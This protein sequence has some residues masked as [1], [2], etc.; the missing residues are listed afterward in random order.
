[1]T[2]AVDFDVAL[3]ESIASLIREQNQ[4]TTRNRRGNDR[5]AYPCVQLLAAFDGT[6]LP[7][8]A[9]FRQV[10]CHDLSPQGFSFL[11]DCRPEASHV[12]VALGQVP[13]RFFVA[14]V[15][16]VRPTETEQGHDYLIGCR[17][18]RRLDNTDHSSLTP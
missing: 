7:S 6:R 18:V 8:Q 16:H 14:E 2:T 15:M 1:M 12:V 5:H 13:F 11:S 17:F 4:A 9:E 3:F 10:L